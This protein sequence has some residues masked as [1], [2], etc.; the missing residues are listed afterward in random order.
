MRQKTFLQHNKTINFYEYDSDMVLVEIYNYNNNKE[1][2]T[3]LTLTGGF[4][5][6]VD[7]YKNN[8]SCI[9]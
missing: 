8:C 1:D 7:C 6:Q 5:F 3:F 2:I 4:D 9:Y